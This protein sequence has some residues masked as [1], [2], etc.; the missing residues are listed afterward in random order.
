[1]NAGRPKQV[2]LTTPIAVTVHGIVWLGSLVLID[3]P[4]LYLVQEQF[5]DHGLEVPGS[6]GVFIRAASAI[7]NWH[8]PVS[9][10]SCSD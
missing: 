8:A 3:S 9:S 6:L 4:I 10:G 5:E 7:H 2:R 1:M